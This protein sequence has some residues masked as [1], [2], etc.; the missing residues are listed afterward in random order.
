MRL[1]KTGI[2]ACRCAELHAEL[3]AARAGLA[4][5]A[6]QAAA[7]QTEVVE[8]LLRALQTALNAAS[9]PFQVCSAALQLLTAQ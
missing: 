2:F 7:H 4:T 8:D 6:E 9:Q 5:Q 1:C 3:A